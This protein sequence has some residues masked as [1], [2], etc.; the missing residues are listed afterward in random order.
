MAADQPV[1]LLLLLMLHSTI[2]I[3]LGVERGAEVQV[4]TLHQYGYEKGASWRE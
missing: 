3:K 1:L 2:E 4:C